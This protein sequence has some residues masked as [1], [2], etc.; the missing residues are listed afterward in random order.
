MEVANNRTTNPAPICVAVWRER[1]GRL[2][3][4]FP[5]AAVLF[6]LADH[7]LRVCGDGIVPG[8]HQRTTAIVTCGIFAHWLFSF[9]LERI[10]NHA[11]C[12]DVSYGDAETAAV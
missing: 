3:L 8:N 10:S 2:R 5:N 4:A 12:M 7:P 11:I 9:R 1:H 6:Q